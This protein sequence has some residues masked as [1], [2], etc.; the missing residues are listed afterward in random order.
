MVAEEAGVP[1]VRPPIPHGRSRVGGVDPVAGV[2]VDAEERFGGGGQ[3]V[4]GDVLKI[5]QV[6]VNRRTAAAI[7]PHAVRIA[8]EQIFRAHE[9][10]GR[11]V[12]ILVQ[13]GADRLER[14][15]VI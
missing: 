3:R 12:R 13:F 6:L 8:T 14:D 2:A 4:R 1:A 9:L 11:E 15:D 5:L 7:L 10:D